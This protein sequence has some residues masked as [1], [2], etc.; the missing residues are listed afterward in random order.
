VIDSGAG[1]AKELFH[2]SKIDKLR[3][4]VPVPEMWSRYARPGAK[5]ELSLAEFPNRTFPCT[6]VRTSGSIET[7]TRT[8]LTEFEVQNSEGELLPGSYVQ[9]HLKLPASASALTVP[10]NTLLFRSEGLRVG[11]VKGG[12]TK[13]MPITVGRD[14]GTKVEVLSGVQPDDSVIL[15]PSDSLIDGLSVRVRDVQGPE[16]K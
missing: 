3:V 16:K 13:L 2:I 11:V 9:V 15:D 14:F 7:S 12:K 5:A 8:L 10:A 4:F 1:S 6:L